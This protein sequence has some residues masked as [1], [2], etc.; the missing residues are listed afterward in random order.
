M[1]SQPVIT[2]VSTSELDFRTA[3][4]TR[5]IEAKLVRAVVTDSTVLDE[6][7]L[8]T[9]EGLQQ[10]EPNAWL[11]RGPNGELWQQAE[12]KLL[13]KY[14]PGNADAEGWTTFTPRPDNAV[15]AAQVRFRREGFAVRGQWGEKQPDGHYLQY[16]EDGDYV[17]QS[18][19]DPSDV[20]IVKRVLFEATYEFAA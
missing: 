19:T 4:K 2:V 14:I 3:A 8:A 11:C 9:L 12:E 1:I 10:L 18:K 13:E 16:G 17:L 15:N 6:L 5:P 7:R 20:W